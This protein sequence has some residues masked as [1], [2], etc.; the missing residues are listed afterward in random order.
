MYSGWSL[1]HGVA[2]ADL[3]QGSGPATSTSR[4]IDRLQ[5]Y[6]L[7]PDCAVLS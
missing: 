3:E 2:K 1:S 5:V 6:A 7:C 4:V